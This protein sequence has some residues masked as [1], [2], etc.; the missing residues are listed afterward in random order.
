MC[1]LTG[2][3][4]FSVDDHTV[5]AREMAEA[6]THRGPDDTGVWVDKDVGI[7]LAHQRLS[8][9]DLSP[10]GH[11]PMISACGRYVLVF[12]GEIYNHLDIRKQLESVITPSLTL[13]GNRAV[14][15]VVTSEA[16]QP[17]VHSDLGLDRH[18][19]RPRDDRKGVSVAEKSIG[20]RPQHMFPD[21]GVRVFGAGLQACPY[22]RFVGNAGAQRIS[23][24]H[25]NVAQ[26]ALMTNPAN[27]AAFGEAQKLFLGPAKQCHQLLPREALALI[28]IGQRAALREPVPRANELAVVAAVNA[29]ADQGAKLWRNRPGMFNRQVRD[30]APRVKPV[31][32]NDGLGRA[33][34]DAGAATAAMPRHR[35]A[36]RQGHIDINFTEKKHRPRFPVE[37]Q[38]VLAAPALPTAGGQLGFE[39]RGRVGEGAVTKLRHMPGN[40]LAEFLQ[41][42]AHQLVIVAATRIKRDNAFGG[43]LKAAELH[44]LP[45]TGVD[46]SGC[47]QIIHSSRNDAHGARNQLGWPCP[48]EPMRR[49]VMHVTMKTR[50]QP[51]R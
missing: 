29:V 17:G 30:A 24:R 2:F 8:I 23:H 10:A 31:G 47:R 41:A 43:P 45:F 11:Q 14:D 46:K 4:S 6:I 27:G 50:G 18:G 15:D 37:Q 38:R 26:P 19:L 5:I 16:K 20:Q 35:R 22:R 34:G 49:H 51:G 12:N 21:H 48:F 28:K 32:R 42:R 3:W 36:R 44:R 40:F 9:L 33:H 25:R 1:G 13:P 39:H 7:A